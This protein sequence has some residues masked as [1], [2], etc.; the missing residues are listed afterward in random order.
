MTQKIKMIYNNYIS[1]SGEVITSRKFG[2]VSWD[3]SNCDEKDL[4]PYPQSRPLG[5]FWILDDCR[6]INFNPSIHNCLSISLLND[7]S[8]V[9]VIHNVEEDMSDYSFLPPP[10]NAAV[11]NADGSLRF[12]LQNPLTNRPGELNFFR[13][14]SL[15]KEN[16]E[17]GLAICIAVAQGQGME[18]FS[19]DGTT[20]NLKDV[21][22][23]SRPNI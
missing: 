15:K 21:T 5:V 8:G 16:G 22:R 11:Y 17:Y 12:I 13:A 6:P 2:L 7:R 1:D 23:T 3:E 20:P 14:G 9:L 18:V 19:I 4:K 10:N